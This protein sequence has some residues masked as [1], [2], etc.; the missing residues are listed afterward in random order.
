M[1]TSSLADV[2]AGANADSFVVLDDQ[3]RLT[4]PEEVQRELDLH[5]GARLAYSII[6]GM[7]V[8][9]P[10][11]KH[12]AVLIDRAA[13]ALSRA[14]L[15][16]QDIIDELPAVR[17]EI[18]RETYGDEFVAELARAHAALHSVEGERDEPASR[19]GND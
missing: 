7:F 19:G 18:M 9:F 3:G 15:T 11:E 10:Q 1:R 2:S 14:G 5:P 16:A 17:A 13:E 6:D 8:L 4:I 12:L